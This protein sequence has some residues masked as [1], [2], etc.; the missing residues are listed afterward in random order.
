MSDERPDFLD[1][2]TAAAYDVMRQLPDGRWCGVVRLLFHWTLHVD[3]D[4]SGYADRYCYREK[5]DAVRALKE[6][7]GT[8]DPEGWHRHPPS[9]RR[10][11]SE[12]NEW[13]AP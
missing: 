6:W 7:D 12:G 5:L 4:W 3:I 13:V 8:G 1:S 9:G 2:E 11:D 10:R